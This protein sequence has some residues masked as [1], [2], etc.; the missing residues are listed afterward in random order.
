MVPSESAPKELSNEWSCFDNLKFCGQFLC[1]VKI[2]LKVRF[3]SL[4][5]CD[6]GLNAKIKKYGT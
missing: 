6:D 5:F 4:Y 1:P 3:A 2:Y